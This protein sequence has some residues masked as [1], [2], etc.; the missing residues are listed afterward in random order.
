MKIETE[1]TYEELAK[2]L[3]KAE[4]NNKPN[5]YQIAARIEELKELNPNIADGTLKGKELKFRWSEQKE[6][7]VHEENLIEQN[8]KYSK[9]KTNEMETALE[10]AKAM[11]NAVDENI[12]GLTEKEFTNALNK[13]NKDNVIGVI[14][15]YKTVSEE[16]EHLIEAIFDETWHTLSTRKEVA[17]TIINKVIERANTIEI[18]DEKTKQ[19]LENC[20]KEFIAG[21]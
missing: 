20:Q 13:I 12:G 16:Q 15:Q 4:G 11:E 7:I 8:A 1:K 19:A 3:Y 6:K 17:N 21:E 10:I 2:S 14:K 18:K 9:Q 5:K